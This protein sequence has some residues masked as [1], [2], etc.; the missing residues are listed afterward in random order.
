MGAIKHYEL[1]E[2]IAS[3]GM[4]TVYRAM[5]TVLEREVAVKFMHQHLL[6]NEKHADRFMQE[7]RLAAKISHPNIV[8]IHEVGQENGQPFIVMELVAG[9]SLFELMQ[10][11]GPLEQ[12]EA[13]K[14][15]CQIL[16][17][18]QSAHELGILHRDIKPD[19]IFITKTGQAKILDF[20]IAKLLAGSGLT[21]AGDLLGT[22]EY[23]APEQ[24][25]DEPLDPRS[26]NYAVGV[27]LYQMLSGHLPFSSDTTAAVLY[28]KLNEPP[29]PLLHYHQSTPK[30]LDTAVQ[31]A[32]HKDPRRRWPS[33][34][35]FA[36]ELVAI[37]KSELTQQLA[38][39]VE[40]FEQIA[41]S[42]SEDVLTGKA[43]VGRDREITQLRE[44]FDKAASGHGSTMIVRGEAGIGKTTLSEK[45]RTY[46]ESKGAWVLYGACLY[47]EGM[48][49]YLPFI[50]ALRGF[51]RNQSNDMPADERLQLKEIVRT[52]VPILMEFTERFDT[53]FGPVPQDTT[54][55]SSGINLP[56]GIYQ[57]IAFLAHK[58]PI[59]LILDDLQWA[60]EASLRLFHYVSRYV[61]G[62]RLLL[63]GIARTER[64]DLARDGSP[65][66]L[67]D[68]LARMRREGSYEEIKIE[69]LDRKV[70]DE[71]V[72][73]L[74][75][76]NLFSDGFYTQVYASTKGNP[77]FVGDTLKLLQ[78]KGDI[79]LQN[80][81]WCNKQ[82]GFQLAVPNRAEDIFVRRLGGLKHDERELLQVMAVQGNQFDPSLAEKLMNLSRIEI[83]KMLQRLARDVQVIASTD[84]GYR[85]EHPMIRDLL[86]HELSQPLRAEYHLL[87][88]EAL[89]AKHGTD[90][91]YVGDIAEHYRLAGNVE[92]AIPLLKKSAD[93]AFGLSASR[94]C[95]I[96]LEHL[97]DALNSSQ[98][99]TPKKLSLKDVYRKLG[100]CYEENGRWE[101]AIDAFQQ[102][103]S[104]SEEEND[105][106]EE[107]NALLRIGRIQGKLGDWTTSLTTYEKCLE[108]ATDQELKNI[109]SRIYNNLGIIY[110]QKGDLDKAL[111]YFQR[112]I[113]A[114]DSADGEFDKAHAFT[115]MG[116]IS[117]IRGDHYDALDSYQKAL[118][119]Y[120]KIGSLNH[121]KA[122]IHHNIGM[123]YVD[124]GASDKAL[125]SFN[126]CLE[127]ANDIEDEQLR[128]L[129]HLNIGRMLV[130]QDEPEK[131][132]EFVEKALK[133]FKRMGDTLNMAEAYHIFG[134]IC[135]CQ[136]NFEAAENY[137]ASSIELNERIGY[138]EGLAETYMS[139]GE[140]FSRQGKHQK[141]RDA[142]H[143]AI[144]FYRKLDSPARVQELEQRIA[145][146][147]DN[148]PKV[149]VVE[150]PA[151]DKSSGKA[152]ERK[153]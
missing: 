91:V 125:A 141:M 40:P 66:C 43:Y 63:L 78:D 72:D 150:A 103:F 67:V 16:E 92:D 132:R 15:T 134:H 23:M 149:T 26:D 58:R 62:N 117:N 76:P 123:T 93:R 116:I 61:R 121:D 97:L 104:L 71:L 139:L 42:V 124:Q 136:G 148:V 35:D 64:P 33:A 75:S 105:F 49:P 73:L 85:F 14:I 53:S 41:E 140:L 129:T 86:Y 135:D 8:T 11:D 65:G 108:L 119:I 10:T 59:V 90:G 147:P 29:L 13:I 52:Q 130:K 94:E 101:E 138:E 111:D 131:A 50:D 80:D 122:Q 145:A 2:K 120:Q 142:C 21:N 44:Q 83:L 22:V 115:N 100:I 69:R 32:I 153:E 110:F 34:A 133:S 47:Q 102:L 84:Q 56:G 113:L 98:Q 127:L 24:L 152:A 48:D 6:E 74:L 20:G 18:M 28:K 143:K 19:N 68:V 118:I 144:E 79:F 7:A 128:A 46:A 146:L 31:R 77:L 107:A 88:A 17:G 95:S 60:D 37:L 112:T 70:C 51:F 151:P 5:D 137:L 4:G 54:A 1:I 45:L 99:Q 89:K 55:I 12:E 109:L 25:L 82:E 81:T 39:A 126:R 106:D 9:T 87:F 3:G 30:R 96:F 36:T 114:V 27:L 57:L 38:I